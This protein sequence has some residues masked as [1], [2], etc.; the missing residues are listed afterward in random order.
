MAIFTNLVKQSNPSKRFELGQNKPNPFKGKTII[1]YSVPYKT[2]VIIMINDVQGQVIQKIV[3]QNQEAGT[4]EIE[5]YA[6][7]LPTGNYFY[8]IITDEF[9]KSREMEII[10]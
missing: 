8:H 3:S 2:K 10:K 9:F 5:F 4:Y 6:D 7:G 1:R